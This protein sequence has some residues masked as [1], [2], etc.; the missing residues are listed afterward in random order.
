LRIAG[1]GS[2]SYA[3]VID[4]HIRFIV[5]L[6]WLVV[7][8]FAYLGRVALLEGNADW[9]QGYVLWVLLPMSAAG[10][11]IVTLVLLRRREI[12]VRVPASE[13]RAG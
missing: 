5:A 1:A 11:S 7:A 6:A 3:F 10:L 13:R 4:W 8:S 9:D 2:R 12:R